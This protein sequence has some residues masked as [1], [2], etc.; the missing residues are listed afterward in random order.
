MFV[1]VDVYTSMINVSPLPV[2]LSVGS[3]VW[4]ADEQVCVYL[5]VLSDVCDGCM[6]KGQRCHREGLFFLTWHAE[7]RNHLGHGAWK[8]FEK[9]K[10]LWKN[11]E[12]VTGQSIRLSQSITGQIQPI[13]PSRALQI[14]I[15]P[16][17]KLKCWKWSRQVWR[18]LFHQ[19]KLCSV[20]YFPVILWRLM[21]FS[22]RATIVVAKQTPTGGHT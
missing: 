19:E 22:P 15:E 13:R 5:S 2:C 3:F 17:G 12:Q 1:F 14:L 9:G 7:P 4:L 10:T 6:V 18:H 16:A 20:K 21:L 8:Q 11:A